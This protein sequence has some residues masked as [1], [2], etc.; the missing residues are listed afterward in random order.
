MLV[1][2]EENLSHLKSVSCD[3]VY[4]LVDPLDGTR[5]FIKRNGQFT[6]NIALIVK[7]EPA[8]GVVYVPV[9]DTCYWGGEHIGAGE[10]HQVRSLK[11]AYRPA[12]CRRAL[13]QARI[14]LMMRPMRF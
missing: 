9:Q 8:F 5:E 11:S 6:V 13:S 7:G 14:I 1:V 2:S 12:I 3:S 10:K 4:W